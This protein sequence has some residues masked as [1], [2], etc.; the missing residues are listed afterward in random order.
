MDLQFQ[1]RFLA[2]LFLLFLFDNWWLYYRFQMVFVIR[3]WAFLLRRDLVAV[4]LVHN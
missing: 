3:R 2:P 4:A 1:T